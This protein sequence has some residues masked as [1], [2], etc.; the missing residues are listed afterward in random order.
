MLRISAA[1]RIAALTKNARKTGAV[2]NAPPKDIARFRFVWRRAAAP[3]ALLAVL[4]MPVSFA[5]QRT[6]NWAG[7]FPPCHR[8]FELLKREPMSLGVKISTSNPMLA[9]E[10]RQAMD[11]WSRVLEMN[12]HEDDSDS[13]AVQLVDGTSAILKTSIVARSQ[14]TE[15]DNFQG[16]IAFNPRAPLSNTEM[17]LTAVH[18]IGHML[19]LKHN[20]STHSVM[21]YLDLEGSEVLDQADLTTLAGRHKLRVASVTEPIAVRQR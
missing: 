8:R 11:F 13:C 14:F 2:S 6:A 12:W 19:G 16:W 9:R 5:D 20:P 18:E 21:Y 10:F 15:W 3:F 7:D 4:T 17:Y 1:I